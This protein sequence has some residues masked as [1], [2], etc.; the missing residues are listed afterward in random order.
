MTDKRDDWND[1]FGTKFD[2]IYAT[3]AMGGELSRGERL[4]IIRSVITEEK[5]PKKE[6]DGLLIWSV[7]EEGCCHVTIDQNQKC[8]KVS[9][10]DDNGRTV[11]IVDRYGGIVFHGRRSVRRLE[12]GRIEEGQLE[13]SCPEYLSIAIMLADRCLRVL[14]AKVEYRLENVKKDKVW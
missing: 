6:I 12:D 10:D 2:L 14:K 9:F 7:D 11:V 5:F 1:Y 3:Y 8:Y 4:R 13:H